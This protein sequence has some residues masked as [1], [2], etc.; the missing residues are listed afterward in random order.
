MRAA[1]GRA[2]VDSSGRGGATLLRAASGGRALAIAW[3]C[4]EVTNFGEHGFNE[5]EDLNEIKG[6]IL[7][8]VFIDY[9]RSD[10]RDKGERTVQL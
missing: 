7:Q 10:G 9:W 3:R 2:G 8:F 5:R 1:G 6:S 4:R